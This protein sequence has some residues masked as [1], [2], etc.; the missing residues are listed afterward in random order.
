MFDR[1]GNYIPD[2][3][4]TGEMDESFSQNLDMSDL[5]IEA[6][7]EQVGPNADEP[8]AD[9]PDAD[10]IVEQED[11]DPTFDPID[12]TLEDDE[13]N[14]NL[15]DYS[16]DDDDETIESE[17]EHDQGGSD[18]GDDLLKLDDQL[19]LNDLA[20]DEN[21]Q[22]I[23]EDDLDDLD[24]D[25]DLDI[26]GELDLSNE[27]D[28]LEELDPNEIDT[29]QELDALD[30]LDEAQTDGLEDDDLIDDDISDILKESRD[31]WE[32]KKDS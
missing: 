4:E 21:S 2:S 1:Q 14:I 5:D 25:P 10:E 24:P 7:L 27:F 31:F 11:I 16:L 28:S 15:P 17:D 18:Q 30:A 9:E 22:Q 20:G 6:T 12:D 26:T 19:N 32:Q 23:P 8:D 29:P 3:E 13:L